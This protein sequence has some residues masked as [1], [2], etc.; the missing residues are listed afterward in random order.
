M[1]YV[2][3]DSAYAADRD[4]SFLDSHILVGFMA[5]DAESNISGYEYLL[6]KAF[7]KELVLDWTRSTVLDGSQFYIT[8]VKLEE[9]S[10][11]VFRV[12]PINGVGLVG[13]E[14][15]SD[16]VIIDTSVR[17]PICQDTI[18]SGNETDVDCG[19]ECG[20][21]CQVNQECRINNDCSL[22][23]CTNNICAQPTCT[24]NITTPGFETDL[25]C[26]GQCGATCANSKRCGV[27][28]DCASFFCENGQCAVAPPCRDRI[29]SSGV[30][31]SDIDCGG[32]CPLKC[33]ENK[34]CNSDADCG[35]GL[36][37]SI[38]N[39]CQILDDSDQ[40][41]VPDERDLCPGTATLPV[42]SDGCAD[43]QKFS[44]ND[45]INDGYRIQHF[46]STQC[47]GDG[48]G[49]A[50]PDR[51]GLTNAE[52]FELGTNPTLK[53]TDGDG[54]SD[55]RE[56]RA[57]KDPRSEISMPTSYWTIFLAFLQI[58]ILLGATG[59]GGFKGYEWYLA[60]KEQI[61]A[62][63]RAATAKR[64]KLAEERR[65]QIEAQRKAQ[66]RKREQE[67]RLRQLRDLAKKKNTKQRDSYVSLEKL[68]KVKKKK[69]IKSDNTAKKLE[70]LK[71]KFKK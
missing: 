14:L 62:E 28:D 69:N 65:K 2:N 35:L 55:G 31:E 37:C 66:A 17:P 64:K 24:D 39:T 63:K 44:C 23:L 16:G 32:S 18:L 45:N 7:T 57:G 33:T 19:G 41:Q 49:D 21:T 25:D 58:L 11:Y 29:L 12:R 9:G 67:K 27:D 20:A 42:D 48:A 4:I 59:F 15:E 38:G 36:W 13:P 46:G 47:I 71:K 30:G 50:D 6:E 53:D 3:D 1:R 70:A 8:G 61:E 26:G 52:E 68:K 40:D 43:D 51:D 10:R 54:F 60:Y 34:N 22:G 56:V 5:D